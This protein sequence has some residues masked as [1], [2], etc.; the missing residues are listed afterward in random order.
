VLIFQPWQCGAYGNERQADAFGCGSTRRKH[1]IEQHSIDRQ[2]LKQSRQQAENDITLPSEPTPAVDQ[3]LHADETEGHVI[4]P[5]R[6]PID[7]VGLPWMKFQIE[8][9]GQRRRFLPRDDGDPMTASYEFL[10]QRPKRHQMATVIRTDQGEVRH[11]ETPF[12]L[13]A[14]NTYS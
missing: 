3:S 11:G 12:K 2:L 14:S 10:A 7:V 5:I 6:G 9:R 1:V 4:Q 8:L 13:S